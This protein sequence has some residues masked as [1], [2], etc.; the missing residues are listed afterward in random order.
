MTLSSEFAKLDRLVHELLALLDEAD[1]TFWHRYLE[2]GVK[3]VQAHKLAGA[4]FI[5]GCYTGQGSFS[6]LKLARDLEQSEP[7]RHRNLNARL[8]ALR[9]EV[10]SSA[11]RIASR[12][13]W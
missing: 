1:E 10:F 8:T 5:L 6:D 13:L 3:N 9:N 2:R 12:E 4:T 7:L 11:S